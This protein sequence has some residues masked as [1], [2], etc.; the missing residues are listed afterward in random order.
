MTRLSR[1]FVA[2]FSMIVFLSMVGVEM[3]YA[4]AN[5]AT[6]GMRITAEE[7]VGSGP[8]TGTV[9]HLLSY[10]PRFS[11][12]TA[13]GQ[14]DRAFSSSYS[15]AAS[16]AETI[17]VRSFTDGDGTTGVSI[18]KLVCAAVDNSAGTTT[19]HVGNAAS[20]QLL[21]FATT[22]AALVPVEAGAVLMKCYNTGYATSSGA[23]DLKILNTSSST[24]ASF[25]VYLI[26]RSS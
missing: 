23:K 8:R 4:T 3:L 25:R 5:Q 14:I 9:T 17:D 20:N 10:E 6:V 2:V 24:A 22:A 26:G 7:P 19:L 12:G 1:S 21:F 16:T 18:A 15:T 11:N 13:L